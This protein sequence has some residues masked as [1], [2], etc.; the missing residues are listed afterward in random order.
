MI[1]R[2]KEK[3]QESKLNIQTNESSNFLV[4]RKFNSNHDNH[5][6]KKNVDKKTT[7]GKYQSV[8]ST[9]NKNNHTT[10]TE[11]SVSRN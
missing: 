10:Y 1:V 11:P 9:N 4:H 5:K 7:N 2:K 8:L 6:Q 3:H